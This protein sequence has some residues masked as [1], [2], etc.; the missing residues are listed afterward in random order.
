[1]QRAPCG[2]IGF[3]VVESVL[4][5]GFENADEDAINSVDNAVEKAQ[6]T[7]NFMVDIFFLVM[8]FVLNVILDFK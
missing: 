7:M 6:L 5:W 3:V 8:I 2:T 1:M 4:S